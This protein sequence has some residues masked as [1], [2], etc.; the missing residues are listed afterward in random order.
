LKGCVEAIL[1]T[2]AAKWHQ[3]VKGDP[4]DLVMPNQMAMV[5]YRQLGQVLP[6]A[7]QSGDDAADIERLTKRASETY[8]AMVANAKRYKFTM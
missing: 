6:I 3:D 1:G 2:Q 7:E 8:T 5:L 4:P